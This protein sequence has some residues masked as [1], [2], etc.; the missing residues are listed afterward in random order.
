MFTF[1]RLQETLAGDYCCIAKTVTHHR[2]TSGYFTALL[3]SLEWDGLPR[4]V[5]ELS[6]VTF[7]VCYLYISLFSPMIYFQSGLLISYWPC[8]AICDWNL[9]P[10]SLGNCSIVLC[11]GLPLISIHMDRTT[12]HLF[13]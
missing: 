10:Q 1:Y 2:R 11:I 6:A 12:L 5:D 13:Y 7:S 4:K 9:S 3:G 8:E